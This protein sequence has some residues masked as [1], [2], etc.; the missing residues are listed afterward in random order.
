MTQSRE[1][2]IRRTVE[3]VKGAK[4]ATIHTYL[5]TSDVFREVVFGM[6]K[7]DAIDKAIETTKLVRSLTKD[8]PNM[9]DTEWNLEFSPECFSDTPVEFAVEICEAVKKLG[10]QQWKTQ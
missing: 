4:R 7:Q 3:S 8:D 2:L 6:S 1:P 9:Q 10:N 5:A